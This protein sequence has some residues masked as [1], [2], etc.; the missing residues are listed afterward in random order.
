MNKYNIMIDSFKNFER[1]RYRLNYDLNEIRKSI[2]QNYNAKYEEILVQIPSAIISAMAAG[3]ITESSLN[4]A[5]ENIII[6]LAKIIPNQVMCDIL[7]W[8]LLLLLCFSLYIIFFFCMSC[9]LKRVTAYKKKH[10]IVEQD[11][12]NYQKE[13]DNIAC[14]SIFVAFEYQKEYEKVNSKKNNLKTFYYFEMLHYL[15]KACF[16]TY[17]LCLYKGKY[18]KINGNPEGV[19]LY[20]IYNMIFLM[21]DLI[22]YLKSRNETLYIDREYIKQINGS[23]T[24]LEKKVVDIRTLLGSPR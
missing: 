12:L 16:T 22:K 23:I 24:R 15:E 4:I 7:G 13:F 3:V 19:E 17:D 14:D 8:G 6:S 1:L 5:K 11:K 18:V 10:N 9:A 21:E 20:R 2:D